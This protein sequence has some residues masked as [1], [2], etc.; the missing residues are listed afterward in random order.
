MDRILNWNIMSGGGGRLAKVVAVVADWNPDM[1]VLT[2]YRPGKVGD[3]LCEELNDQGLEHQYWAP[4]AHAN[5]N[6]VLV[7]SRNTFC[8]DVL[9]VPEDLR[10][11]AVTLRVGKLNVAAAFCS[12]PAVGKSFLSFLATVGRD[13]EFL[14]IGDFFYGPRGSDAKAGRII[15]TYLGTRWLDLWA[16]GSND[17]ILWSHRNASGGVSRPDHAWCTKGIAQSFGAVSYAVEPLDE[18]VSDH[19]PMVLEYLGQ[20]DS[21]EAS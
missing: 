21:V 3:R 19:A 15:T 10:A 13:T 9:V 8:P 2:E 11:H 7:A 14:A 20:S 17:E 1:V 4:A 12:T 6:T 16:R 5:R 18:R